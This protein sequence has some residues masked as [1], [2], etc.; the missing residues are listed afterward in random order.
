MT[1]LRISR[2]IYDSRVAA[3]DFVDALFLK[4]WSGVRYT[5]VTDAKFYELVSDASKRSVAP[6]FF[7]CVTL[8]FKCY[9]KC[10]SSQFIITVI[11]RVTNVK[12][13]G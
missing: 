12:P 7:F 11:S 1:N 4:K 9:M 8:S 10:R 5:N 2:L 13:K 6:P 3:G